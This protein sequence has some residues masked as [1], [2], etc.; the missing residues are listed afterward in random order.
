VDHVVL[1]QQ[2]PLD[3]PVMILAFRGWND[4]GDAASTALETLAEHWQAKR[5]AHVDPEEFY[6]FQVNRPTV[7]LE[8]GLTRRLDWPDN[9]FRWSNVGG[10]DVVL[11]LGTEPNLR[12]KTFTAEILDLARALG[13]DRVVTLGAFLADVPHT[14]GVPIV[15]TAGSPDEAETLGLSPSRYEGPTGIVGVLQDAAV[16]AG[17]GG[18]SLWAAV[19]HYVSTGENP[20]AAAALIQHLG[21]VLA[22]SIDTGD[23]DAEAQ[24]WED[25]I[26]EQVRENEVLAEYI[27][28]LEEA[29]EEPDGEELAE[30]IQ[31][32]LDQREGGEG[33]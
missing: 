11:F 22:V 29:R 10:H 6:D 1:E 27:Q 5:F 2:P 17:M 16:R 18:V 32:F 23:L 7:R 25:S 15:G 26:S 30:E 13:A 20:K 24:A 28:G 8:D 9:V 14:R 3:H 12:W 19:P 4:A 33:R 21:R 31:R